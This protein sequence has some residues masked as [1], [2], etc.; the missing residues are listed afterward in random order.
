MYARVYRRLLRNRHLEVVPVRTRLPTESFSVYD[1]AEPPCEL[2]PEP[3]EAVRFIQE[4]EA[5]WPDVIR[6]RAEVDRWWT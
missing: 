2:A 6:L 5:R 4:V 3:A 1:F